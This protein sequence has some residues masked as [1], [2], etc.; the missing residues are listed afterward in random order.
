[1]LHRWPKPRP[2]CSSSRSWGA[3]PA[4]LP[5]PA[6]LIED[7]DV[8]VLL[9]LLPE[10]DFD[11]DRFIA[12]VQGRR[13]ES[14]SVTAPWSCPR[15]HATPTGVFSPNQGTRDA[16][17][18]AQLGGVAPVVANMIQGCPGLQI[19]TGPLRTT[20]SAPRVT[21]P[22][23]PTSSRPTRSGSRGVEMALDGAQLDHAHHRSRLSDNPYALGNWSAPTSPA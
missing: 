14:R 12:A 5:P 16:F 3:T 10:V 18:H 7:Y 13:F 4:G 19:S 1:M 17:G 20:C 11:Q 8:P 9:L 15:A 23:Q 6:G 21:S 22:R 2:R